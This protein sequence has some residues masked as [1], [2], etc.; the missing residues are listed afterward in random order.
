MTSVA[1]EAVFVS[2]TSSSPPARTPLRAR[3][4]KKSSN[5][6]RI[7]TLPAGVVSSPSFRPTTTSRGHRREARDPREDPAQGHVLPEGHGMGLLDPPEDPPGRTP[8]DD[9]VHE[10]ARAGRRGHPGEDRRVESAGQGRD[11]ARLGGARERTREGHGVLGPDDEADRRAE[12]SG[13]PPG[14]REDASGGHD[15]R[16]DAAAPPTLD[17]RHGD[18]AAGRPAV[19]AQPGEPRGRRHD[20]QGGESG[21]RTAA[22]ERFASGEARPAGEAGSGETGAGERDRGDEDEWTPDP[23]EPDEGTGGLAERGAPDRQ[24]PERPGVPRPFGERERAGEGDEPAAPRRDRG[25]GDGDEQR[26]EPDEDDVAE[27]GE[28][29]CP[30]AADRELAEADEPPEE[31]TPAHGL[32]ADEPGGGAETDRG[33]VP[34]PERR[35]GAA[36]EAPGDRG[37][38]H[39]GES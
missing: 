9:L 36:D 19:R 26:L 8:G 18:D 32:A 13:R 12:R 24:A 6:L 29:E 20:D 3:S 25:E 38:G 1:Y 21:E 33:E 15:D 5:E 10:P 22:G 17:D 39:P 28:L 16:A 2:T 35:E 34:G 30:D 4:A 27:P 23:G 37:E 31:K 7:A 14:R 11:T